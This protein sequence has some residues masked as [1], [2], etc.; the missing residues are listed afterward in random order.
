MG[1]FILSAAPIVPPPRIRRFP[2]RSQWVGF[3]GSIWDLHTGAQGVTLLNDGLVGLHLPKFD[4]YLSSS[5]AVPGH[6]R[7]GSRAR[8]RD[9][10]W[11]LLVH[12]DTADEWLARDT[13]F[14]HTIHPDLE[15]TWRVGVGTREP[16]ELRLTARGDDDHEYP[17]DP[18]L[19]GWAKY[20]AELE[21]AQPFW[22][23]PVERRFLKVGDGSPID[24]F[25]VAGSPPFHITNGQT[26]STAMISNPGDV[27]A[28]PTWTAV[29]PLTDIQIGVGGV[30]IDVPFDLVT[31]E[32]LVIDSDPRNQ[33]ATL[34]GV[35][36]TADLGF[37]SF[38]SVA[39]GQ[40]QALTVVAAGSGSITVEL[41]PLYF[42]AF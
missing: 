30:T 4:R 42:R 20:V 19:N 36:A 6:R 31:D 21:A 38:A 7:R 24:F 1:V 16:R 29:G 13:G 8:A 14:W 3:D 34:D 26:F 5:R 27:E 35:D 11:P 22:T 10:V 23:G 37:Q 28:Y 17:L 18:Y 40:D 9:V 39:P 15:G 32:V 25:D 41:V 12:G 33:T 2:I